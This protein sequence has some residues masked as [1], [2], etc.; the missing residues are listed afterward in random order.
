MPTT[1]LPSAAGCT[2]HEAGRDWDAI[3]VPLNLG[4]AAMGILGSRCGA[5][6]EDRTV[7][8]YFVPVGTAAEWRMVA[9]RALG[10]GT[11]LTIPPARRTQGPGPHWRI[12]PGDGRWVTNPEALAA[13]LDDARTSQESAA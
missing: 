4:Q 11:S 6:V 5:V 2:L 9:T 3:R 12:T 7:L 10:A 8:Y 13:A 1:C